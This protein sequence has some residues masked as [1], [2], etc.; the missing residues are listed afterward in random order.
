MKEKV[1]SR[2]DRSVWAT[3]ASAWLLLALS[4]ALITAGAVHSNDTA[5]LFGI[6]IVQAAPY[7]LFPM[8]FAVSDPTP[9]V[10]AEVVRLLES[11]TDAD[12]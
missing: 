3:F 8:A 10:A 6:M 11:L 1:S 7:L 5:I 9:A 12:F 4:I 2:I